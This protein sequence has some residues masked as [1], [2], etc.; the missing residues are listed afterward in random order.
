MLFLMLNGGTDYNNTLD[1]IEVNDFDVVFDDDNAG[2]EALDDC[3]QASKRPVLRRHCWP[4][5]HFSCQPLRPRRTA[6]TATMRLER[7]APAVMALRKLRGS[8]TAVAQVN[9]P[10]A[11]RRGTTSNSRT[12]SDPRAY[13]YAQAALGTW[14]KAD[15]RR[16]TAGNARAHTAVSS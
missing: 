5:Q 10:D 11:P 15:P 6:R 4:P 8:D 16:R 2:S 14:W 1:P 9:L 13:G 12:Y 3:S 7:L